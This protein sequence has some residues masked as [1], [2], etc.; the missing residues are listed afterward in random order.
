MGNFGGI[1]F[2]KMGKVTKFICWYYIANYWHTTKLTQFNTTERSVTYSLIPAELIIS[3]SGGF[4]FMTRTTYTPTSMP[5]LQ[6]F[7]YFSSFVVFIF[8]ILKHL[9]RDYGVQHFC[10]KIFL[11]SA[12]V[13]YTSREFLVKTPKLPAF[14]KSL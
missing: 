2:I 5:V 10:W 11:K 13:I 1:C 12:S 4:T 14:N 7:F 6:L 9:Y 3:F 8:V